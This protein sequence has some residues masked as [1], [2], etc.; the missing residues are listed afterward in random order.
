MAVVEL[1]WGSIGIPALGNDQDVGSTTEGVGEDGN[2]SEVDIRVVAWSLAG[3]ATV[4]VPL[5]K[6]LNLELT[7]LWDLGESLEI[8]RI[9]TRPNDRPRFGS[10]EWGEVS[11]PLIWNEH[12]Q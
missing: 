12:H 10:H 7:I 3:R 2:G 11:S 8:T 4:K 6:V 5:G 1:V 9:S